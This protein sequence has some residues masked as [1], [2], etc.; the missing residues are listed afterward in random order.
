ME[1]MRTAACADWSASAAPI[2]FCNYNY[3]KNDCL[4]TDE[5][6]PE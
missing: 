2:R 6:D 4:V 5:S 1:D 3:T